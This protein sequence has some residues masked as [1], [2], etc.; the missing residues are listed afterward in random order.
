M[1]GD[2]LASLQHCTVAHFKKL[3]R[4]RSTVS[5]A[6]SGLSH[7]CISNTLLSLWATCVTITN[8]WNRSLSLN[9]YFCSHLDQGM[10]GIRCS[11]TTRNLAAQEYC[12]GGLYMVGKA[13]HVHREQRLRGVNPLNRSSILTCRHGTSVGIQEVVVKF[14]QSSVCIAHH[15]QGWCGSRTVGKT[16]ARGVRKQV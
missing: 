11:Y 1:V 5:L 14:S 16:R 6:T 4:A 2:D 7:P 8:V 12:V 13:V 3:C 9:Y 15:L 10:R